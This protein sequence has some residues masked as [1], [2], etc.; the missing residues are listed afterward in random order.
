MLPFGVLSSDKNPNNPAGILETSIDWLPSNGLTEIPADRQ[1][2]SR[3][4]LFRFQ[5]QEK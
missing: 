1:L 5:V 4:L 3:S 2:R